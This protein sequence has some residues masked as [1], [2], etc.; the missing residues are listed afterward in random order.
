MGCLLKRRLVVNNDDELM[1]AKNSF[2]QNAL[3]VEDDPVARTLLGK[4][5][6]ELGFRV[7]E[8]VDGFDAIEKLSPGIDLVFL[9]LSMPGKDGFDFLSFVKNEHSTVPVIV[10]SNAEIEDAI[11]AVEEGAFW[12]LRKPPRTEEIALY[13]KRA[14]EVAQEDHQIDGAGISS[15]IAGESQ[16]TRSLIQAVE[17]A[18]LSRRPILITGKDG[19]GKSHIARVIHSHSSTNKSSLIAVGCPTLPEEMLEAYIFG[20]AG[21]TSR[22]EMAKD[23]SCYINEIGQLPLKIQTRLV[24]ELKQF[25]NLRLLA[26]SSED[27]DSLARNSTF[28]K[29][30]LQL[31]DPVPIEILPLA[32]RKVDIPAIAL[33]LLDDFR[34]R[35]GRGPCRFD[36]NAIAVLYEHDWPGNIRE[37][38]NV[39]EQS[40]AFCSGPELTAA[41]LLMRTPQ[42]VDEDSPSIIVGNLSLEKIERHAIIQTLR[43]CQGNRAET[44]RRL[45]VSERTIYNKIKQHGLEE[46]I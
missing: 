9:D 26:S 24:E 32:E 30:L 13:A 28:S 42:S 14:L 33:A 31:F 15:A 43:Q 21:V 23:G 8:A 11:R 46:L 38:A 3:I 12:F 7:E 35:I 36:E 18:T 6:R 34:N 25:P 17:A 39:I 10:V 5:L 27:V 22:L 4:Q 37:L 20:S 19:V 41:D 44:A 45:R 1:E 29:E 2:S 16:H 40:S